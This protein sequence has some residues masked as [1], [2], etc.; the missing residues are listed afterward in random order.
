MISGRAASAAEIND[1]LEAERFGDA[2]KRVEVWRHPARLEPRDGRLRASDASS[3]L[4]LCK[5]QAL[6][7][8]ADPRGNLKC[9]LGMP[10]TAGARSPAFR[11]SR[12]AW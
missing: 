9:F 8:F 1:E 7:C 10:M 4:G 3:E 6:A 2:M 11:R 12:L 5:A